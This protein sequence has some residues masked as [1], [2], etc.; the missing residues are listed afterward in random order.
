[1]IYIV[2]IFLLAFEGTLINISPIFKN[3][4]EMLF[5]CLFIMCLYKI[6]VKKENIILYK[7]EIISLIFI[8]IYFIL[9]FIS[10]IYSRLY[11]DYIFSLGSGILTIK[12]LL[13]YYMIRICTNNIK[14]NI[15]F[16]IIYDK[17]LSIIL[18]MYF[19]IAILNLQFNFLQGWGIRY[20][21]NTIAVGFT[22]PATFEFFILSIIFIKLFIKNVL[23][24]SDKKSLIYLTQG[25]ILIFW[26]GRS[27]GIS[28][29]ILSIMLL[30]IIQYS[31]KLKIRYLLFS[32]PIIIYLSYDRIIISLLSSEEARNV[33]Y[34]ISVKIANDFFPFGSGFSTFG[35]DFSRIRY[36]VIYFN[37][38]INN[39]WGLS[40]DRYN[41]ITDT[42]WA[43]IMGETGYFGV[44]F[45]V[46]SV[47]FITIVVYKVGN[48]AISKFTLTG[49]LIY[50]LMASL[51]DSILVSFRGMAIFCIIGFFVSSI[52]SKDILK[53]FN[54]EGRINEKN[55][56]S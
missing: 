49:I 53:T 50:G 18:N 52:K 32:V 2:I 43:M 27:K 40:P 42:Q 35:S 44:V 15:K 56:N 3:I 24:L 14:I 23:K 13:S 1:M 54:C 6:F 39:V 21:F 48:N 4:D 28:F 8:I 41:F 20:G 45:Y 51:S 11:N 19:F 38:G 9:G 46:L 47:L 31:K 37:Y 17:F 26:G 7:Y 36:S 5:I 33:L 34:R 25:A 12:S 10:F 30:M 22:H 16:I 55:C 29:I